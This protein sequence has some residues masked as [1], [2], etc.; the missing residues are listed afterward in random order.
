MSHGSIQILPAQTEQ[1]EKAVC[2]CVNNGE[3]SRDHF[4]SLKEAAIIGHQILALAEPESTRLS[5]VFTE[6]TTAN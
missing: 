3:A 4:L 6:L 1:G 2:L 5:K